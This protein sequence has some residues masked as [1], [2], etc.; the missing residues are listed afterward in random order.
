MDRTVVLSNTI[1]TI[2]D[3]NFRLSW[4]EYFMLMAYTIS[5]R[6]TCGRLKVGCVFTKNNRIISS[7]YNGHVPGAPHN[8]KVRNGHEQLTIHAETNAIC[9]AANFG[10]N[11]SNSTVYVTHYPCIN[12]TK[13]LI[14]SGITNIIYM[15]DYHNDEIAQK[16]LMSAGVK[17]NKMELKLENQTK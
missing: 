8:S 10:T 5:K 14:A 1:K 15:E 6:S 4:D 17:V 16:L 3:I 2:K 12:C 11:I 13:A 7:G 9:H